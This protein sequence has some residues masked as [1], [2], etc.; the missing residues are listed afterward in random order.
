MLE[1]SVDE[2]LESL[3]ER[4]NI[5]LPEP[6]QDIEPA[7]ANIE[8]LAEML[9]AVEI[10]PLTLEPIDDSGVDTLDPL[11]PDPPMVQ[12]ETPQTEYQKDE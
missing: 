2:I 11:A 7:A 4:A 6:G 9:G 8:E 10:D 1:E 5:P 12:S 3:R